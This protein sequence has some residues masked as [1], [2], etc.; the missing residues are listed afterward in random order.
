MPKSKRNRLVSLTATKKKNFSN[1]KERLVKDVQ[2]CVDKYKHCFVFR[3]ENMRNARLKELRNDLRQSRFF[4]GKN[5]VM[6]IGLG[7][8]ESDEYRKNIHRIT[9]LL[10]G[11]CDFFDSYRHRDYARTGDIATETIELYEGP[12]EQFP[13]NIEPYLRQLGMPTTL[14][15][16]IVTL[17]KDYQ[18]CRK[19]QPLTSEQ[20]RILKLLDNQM[21][22]FRITIDA[23]WC[24]DDGKF[25]IFNRKKLAEKNQ[26]TNNNDDDDTDDNDNDDE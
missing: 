20:A 15:K 19:G 12:M 17:L 4:F 11:Q 24:N 23:M 8:T 10:S 14:Q 26:I 5:K 21:A 22:E 7:R 9:K 13:H 2:D 16:G 3:V 6:S 25:E 18:V 1:L